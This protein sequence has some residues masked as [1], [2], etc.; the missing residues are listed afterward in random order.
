MWKLERKT[1]LRMR[2]RSSVLY[3]SGNS[4]VAKWICKK[5]KSAALSEITEN[6]LTKIVK[7]A[8]LRLNCG[9]AHARNFSN[10]CF[11]DA[12]L[13]GKSISSRKKSV[14]ISQSAEN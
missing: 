2:V 14:S 9:Y 3:S 12:S 4:V 13:M 11:L 7:I 8:F 5:E 6:R 10:F 1:P